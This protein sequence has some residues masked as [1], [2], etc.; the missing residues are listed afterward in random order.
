MSTTA[1][2]TSRPEA[3]FV[4]L[5]LQAT[6]WASAGISA[7][8]FV[9]G[10]EV[11]M[12]AL[13]LASIAFAGGAVWLAVGLVRRRRWARRATLIIEWIT[14]AGSLL[15]LVIPIGANHGPVAL[16]VNIALPLAVI[17]LL[18]GRGMKA[19]FGITATPSR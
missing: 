2:E 15:L 7:L 19:R 9:L 5:V 3:A 8:P 11:H 4:L 13:A 18:R 17:L 6:F 16:L 10:G 12:L 1:G 14:F